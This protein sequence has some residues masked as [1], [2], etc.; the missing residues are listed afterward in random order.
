MVADLLSSLGNDWNY[1][2]YICP[3][4]KRGIEPTHIRG[5]VLSTV[6]REGVGRG[7][8]LRVKKSV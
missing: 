5:S 7:P 6:F 2:K 8:G 4:D 1:G 3:R